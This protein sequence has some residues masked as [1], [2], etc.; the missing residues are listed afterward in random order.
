MTDKNRRDF[1]KNAG[2]LAGM[3]T[4][5]SAFPPVIRQALAIEAN[6]ATKSIMDVEHVVILMQEN[7]SFD[8][9]F[10][11]MSG[12]RGFGDRLAMPLPDGRNAFQ[13]S[14]GTRIVTPYHLDATQGNAQRVSGTPHSWSDAQNAWD[15]GRMAQWPLYKRDHSMGHYEEAELEFQYA[16]ANAFTVCDAY[17]CALHGGTNPN[18]MFLWTGTNGPTGAGVAQVVNEWDDL[19][20]SS[21]GFTWKTYPERLQDAGVTWKVYQNMPDNYTDNSLHGFRTYRKANEDVGNNSNGSPY[22][23][24]RQKLERVNPLYKGCGNTMPKGGLLQEFAGDVRIGHLPQVSWIVAPRTYSEH[25]G[26]SS[27]VQGAWYTQKVLASLVAYPEV[28]SKTVLIVNFDENDGF[29][30]HMPPPCVYSMNED[31]T[32]AGASTIKESELTVERFVHPKPEGTRGQPSPDGR[33]YGPGPRVPCYIVSPWSRGGWV[34]SET[35]DHTSVL[36]FLETRFGVAETNVSPYRKAFCGDLMSAFDFVNPNAEVPELPSR[37]KTAADAIRAEQEMRAQVPV[38]AEADQAIPV[39]AQG[40]RLSRPLPYD[41]DVDAT[42]DADSIR[43]RFRNLGTAGAVFH[44]YDKLHLDRVPRR[45]SVE[46]GKHLFGEW[47]ITGDDGRYDLWLLGPNGYHRHFVGDVNEAGKAGLAIPEVD[48]RF[49]RD[50]QHVNIVLTNNG[51]RSCHLRIVANA[52][53]TYASNQHLS[54]GERI[55]VRRDL[56]DSSNWYDYT[57]YD[58]TAGETEQSVFT[59]RYAGRMEN[60]QPSVSDPAFGQV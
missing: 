24:Y 4:A 22:T 25:P 11:T 55:V 50:S 58:Y 42:T 29:F 18:R 47:D 41:L 46:A 53:E 38:P 19:G 59:R 39:Q 56:K 57:I 43:L 44:V 20:P 49:D 34:N 10:G 21:E 60:G 7:R 1:L 9:Y 52:Y 8:H 2:A 5:M 28:W 12:V 16:L 48:F 15:H 45:Y 32:P 30:D 31:G 33:V 37:T 13:Q 6:N 26:P 3:A 51:K 17:H 36:R 27:P 35:F 54:P 23:E 14:N 40:L